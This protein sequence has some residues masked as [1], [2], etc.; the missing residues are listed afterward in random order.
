MSKGT[1]FEDLQPKKRFLLISWFQWRSNQFGK[2]GKNIANFEGTSIF[3]PIRYLL[4][5]FI[6]CVT[7]LT[8]IW[9]YIQIWFIFQCYKWFLGKNVI[10]RKRRIGTRQKRRTS[11]STCPVYVVFDVFIFKNISHGTYTN[12]NMVLFQYMYVVLI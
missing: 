7:N 10:R 5:F 1:C 9:Y 11:F 12:I 8:I 6:W 3:F 2:S 4:W